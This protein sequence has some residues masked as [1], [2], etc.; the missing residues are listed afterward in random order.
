MTDILEKLKNYISTE[1][2]YWDFFGAIRIIKDSATLFET[3][4]G[5]ASIEFDIKN[6]METRFE[7]ASVSKQFTAFAIM[8]LYDRGLLH[9]DEE[10]NKYLP[11]TLQLPCR[12][13]VHQL[14][15]HTSG[16]HN[17]YNFEDD[18]Y[19]GADRMPYDREQFFR[20]WILKDAVNN[21]KKKTRKSFDYNNSN[22]NLLAWIIETV[23]GQTYSEFMEEN[24]FSKLGMKHT[25]IDNGQQIL[26]NKANNYMHDYGVLVSVPYT[27][28]L[29][30]IGAGA[31]VTNCDDLQKW[32]ECLRTK[33][34]LSERSYK[35]FLSENKN[36]YCYGL[37]RYAE[38]SYLHGGDFLGVSSYTQYFFDE[39]LCILILS[40]NESLSQYRL[41]TGI[42]AILHH[43]Q[44]PISRRPE[45]LLLTP[46]DLAKYTGTYLPGKIQIEEKNGKLYLVRVNQNIH[47]E[48][49]CIGK[50]SFIRRYEEQ[51]TPHR[52]IPDGGGTPSIWGYQRIS[53]AFF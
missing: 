42:S 43:G 27:N 48:L 16:L 52:L 5:Y 39:N 17:N 49:Y 3:S 53:E 4:R 6:T 29:Y 44:A 22:Y 21:P 2:N 20:N 23:S 31:L 51:Q 45:E 15:C 25:A 10:A 13:T 19:V 47:I 12:I 33:D 50:D 35:I 9:L 8:L 40:N 1:L 41:G 38:N 26:H 34:L 46:H 7:V 18:F 28:S 30:S 11:D 24:I 32:Y 14:L 36:H 37:E